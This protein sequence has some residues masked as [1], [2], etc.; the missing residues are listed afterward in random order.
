MST[1]DLRTSIAQLLKEINDDSVLQAVYTLLSRTSANQD[2]N[3]YNSLS[4]KDKTLIEV[5][6]QQADNGELI[7][8]E[9]VM[10][11]VDRLLGRT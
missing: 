2:D 6:I 7:P 8:H 1:A 4:D 10:L 3:W 9:Q 11:E 5:G